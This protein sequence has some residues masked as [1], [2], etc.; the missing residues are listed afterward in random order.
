[1]SENTWVAPLLSAIGAGLVTGTSAIIASIVQAG[2]TR[3][4]LDEKEKA[5]SAAL[6][7]REKAA[8]LE[9]I[10]EER[11]RAENDRL[12]AERHLENKARYDELKAMMSMGTEGL[13]ITRR[14]AQLK[15]EGISAEL[16]RVNARLETIEN[17]VDTL[18]R[19]DA[20]GRRRTDRPR[21]S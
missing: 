4:Q 16:K 17:D 3:V 11:R 5:D 15:D 14:E 18:V 2:K 1:M 6:V 8:D 10:E 12:Q 21:G 19:R 9:R 13:F 7:A 20:P